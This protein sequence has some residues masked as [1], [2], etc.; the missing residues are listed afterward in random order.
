MKKWN[1]QAVT[2]AE[3]TPEQDDAAYEALV[4]EMRNNPAYKELEAKCSAH[5]Y[6][7]MEAYRTVKGLVYLI[8]Q[9]VDRKMCPEM[10]PHRKSG[11][12]SRTPKVDDIG[13]RI[14]TFSIGSLPTDEFEVYLSNHRNAYE[15]AVWM[16]AWEGWSNLIQ[17]ED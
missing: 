3:I 16:E 15:L 8:V 7:L 2:A 12:L 14:Q 17:F 13:F 10:Y 11:G 1:K 4:A 9:P 6:R 5:G